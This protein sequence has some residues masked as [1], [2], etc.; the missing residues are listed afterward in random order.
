M[1]EVDLRDQSVHLHFS[2][3]SRLQPG[4][5]SILSFCGKADHF[6]TNLKSV[7][8]GFITRRLLWCLGE[9]RGKDTLTGL[10]IGFTGHCLE[11]NH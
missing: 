8:V 6:W 10:L 3:Q 5:P 1:T 11:A 7:S 9:G 2:C 4:S